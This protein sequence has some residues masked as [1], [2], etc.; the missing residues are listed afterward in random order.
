MIR[1]GEGCIKEDKSNSLVQTDFPLR[2]GTDTIIKNRCLKV[3]LVD[4][5]AGGKGLIYFSFIWT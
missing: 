3:L 2:L 4:L 5:A 1:S